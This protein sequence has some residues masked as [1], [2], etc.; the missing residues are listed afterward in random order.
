MTKIIRYAS[1]SYNMQ[2][3]LKGLVGEMSNDTR[4]KL[5]SQVEDLQWRR[6]M[7]GSQ[8][9]HFHSIPLS[10]GYRTRRDAGLRIPLS[11][12]L[13]LVVAL[14]L[15]S[16]ERLRWSKDRDTHFRAQF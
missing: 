14:Y 10:A 4:F 1:S 5:R 15:V 3:I 2:V 8:E 6:V 7:Y 9:G 13:R 12:Y 16:V 11:A